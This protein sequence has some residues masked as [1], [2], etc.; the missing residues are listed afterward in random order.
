MVRTTLRSLLLHCYK[1]NLRVIEV[2]DWIFIQR[3]S[4]QTFY[5][6]NKNVFEGLKPSFEGMDLLKVKLTNFLLSRARTLI[7]ICLDS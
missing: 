5:V 4:S 7:F 6:L 3:L 2:Y 1:L